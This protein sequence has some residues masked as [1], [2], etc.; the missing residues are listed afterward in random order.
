MRLTKTAIKRRKTNSLKQ[1]L[2]NETGIGKFEHAMHLLYGKSNIRLKVMADMRNDTI[3]LAKKL[4]AS[5]P[6]LKN[7][8]T[9]LKAVRARG[10][11]TPGA[12]EPDIAEA[13]KA[14]WRIWQETPA[15]RKTH[16]SM[17]DIA[18]VFTASVTSKS[19]GELSD[20]SVRTGVDCAS[21]DKIVKYHRIP[22]TAF[23]RFGVACRSM[24]KMWREIKLVAGS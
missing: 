18:L 19:Q 6:T 14:V 12:D 24:S 15:T 9:A 13:A 20:L 5:H 22:E 8:M 10:L 17:K 4:L 16:A 21:I 1:H 7:I 2:K 3:K 11:I 23:G